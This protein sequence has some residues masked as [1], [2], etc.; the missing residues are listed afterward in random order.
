MAKNRAKAQKE[1]KRQEQRARRR[2]AQKDAARA[3]EEEQFLRVVRLITACSEH[4]ADDHGQTSLELAGELREVAEG[5]GALRDRW[6]QHAS[7]S[8]AE[9][10]AL[11][12]E[13]ARLATRHADE[14][15]DLARRFAAHA[16]DRALHEHIEGV[17]DEVHQFR[18]SAGGGDED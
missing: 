13:A 14:W 12:D 3:A 18:E 16:A 10:G 11:L 1:R 6:A 4:V 15:T 17:G 7:A 8:A 9:L 5:T 2:E